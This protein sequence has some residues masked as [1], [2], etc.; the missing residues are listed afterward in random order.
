MCFAVCSP[1][2]LSWRQQWTKTLSEKYRIFLCV[3]MCVSAGK[4]QNYFMWPWGQ[5]RKHILVFKSS[6]PPGLPNWGAWRFLGPQRSLEMCKWAA[7][8]M[9]RGCSDTCLQA[10]GSSSASICAAESPCNW[11]E[12]VR[13]FSFRSTFLL[14][15]CSFQDSPKCFLSNVCTTDSEASFPGTTGWMRANSNAPLGFRWM[16]VQPADW[17]L[18][19]WIAFSFLPSARSLYAPWHNCLTSCITNGFEPISSLRQTSD[20]LWKTAVIISPLRRCWWGKWGAWLW[21]G[22]LGV[23]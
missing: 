9:L 11:D 4:I 16:S 19:S 12:G 6:M 5:I 1:L 20:Q 21:S 22:S 14:S 17:K 15:L 3:C 23:K 2:T 7:Q 13:S 18:R 10:P 8:R